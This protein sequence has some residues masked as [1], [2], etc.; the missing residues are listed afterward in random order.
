[1]LSS[2]FQVWSI[3][4]INKKQWFSLGWDHQT[5]TVSSMIAFY[6]SSEVQGKL[7]KSTDWLIEGFFSYTFRDKINHAWESNKCPVH[8]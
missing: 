3:T 2:I 4:E 6:T 5:H 8:W 1:M 7:S